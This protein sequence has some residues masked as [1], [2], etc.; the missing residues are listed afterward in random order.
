VGLRNARKKEGLTGDDIRVSENKTQLR[1]YVAKRLI[2]N[3][4]LEENNE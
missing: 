2:P 3:S 4:E 1:V